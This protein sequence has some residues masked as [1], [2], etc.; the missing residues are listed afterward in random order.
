MPL[1]VKT[2]TYSD[3]SVTAAGICFDAAFVDHKWTQVKKVFDVNVSNSLP[4][5]NRSLTWSQVLGTYFAAQLAARQ[6]SKQGKGGSIVLIAS[7]SAY[8]VTQSHKLSAYNASKAAVKMLGT[9]LSVELGPEMI[10]VNSISPGYTETEMLTPY[11]D[12]HPERIEIMNTAPPLG[13]IGNRNDL[14]PA[15]IYLLSDA[16]TYTS[17]TDIQITGALHCGRINIK[18]H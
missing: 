12:E 1:V 3:D 18:E 17:G 14:T 15:V 5:F 6:M 7:I 4:S 10:R 9:A 13:R 2:L 11:K 16:S 8:T